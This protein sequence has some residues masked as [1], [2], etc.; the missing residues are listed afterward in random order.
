M[1]EYF[2]IYQNAFEISIQDEDSDEVLGG[3]ADLVKEETH[4]LEN[5][6]KM[7]KN[8]DNEEGRKLAVLHCKHPKFSIRYLADRIMKG[9]KFDVIDRSQI[10][11]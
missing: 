7:V 8:R 10:S 3:W 11:L 1:L 4:L 9:E 5:V 2:R 6:L